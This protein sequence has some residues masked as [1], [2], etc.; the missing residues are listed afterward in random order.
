MN[1]SIE[2]RSKIVI[3]FA[4]DSG[5]GMQLTGNQFTNNSALAGNDI[6]TFPDYPAEI[7]APLGTVAGVSGFQIQ[8]SSLDIFTP[9]DE[10]DVLVAMNAAALKTNIKHIKRGGSI[11]VN[12][13]GFDKK[14]LRLA[15]YESNPLEDDSLQGFKVVEMDITQRTRDALAESKL[16]PKE[17]DRS[18]NMFVLGFLYW[19]YDRDMKSTLDFLNAKF[20][21]KPDILDANTRVLKAGYHYGEI[22]DTFSTRFKVEAAELPKGTY[23]GIMGNIAA[24]YGL[25]AASVKSGL[26]LYLG[27]YPITPA[28]DILHELSKQK[29]FGVKTFQAEDEIAAVSS[30]I[31]A[32]FAGNLAVTSTSGPGLALKGEAIG[33]A[34]MLELPLVVCNIMRA[35]PST[36]MPTKTEQSDLLQAMYGRNGESPLVVIAAESPSDCFMTAFEAARIAIEH[37]TPVIFLSDG[38]LGNGAEPWKFPKE[39]DLPNIKVKFATARN[40]EDDPPFYPYQRD[41]NLVRPWAIPGTK[42]LEHRVGGLAKED[43]TGD[44][45]Y[46]ADNHQKMTDLRQA[47]IDRI[48]FDIPE[49]AIEEGKEKGKLLVIA[50]GS[51][52]GA[53]KSVVRD[54]NHEGID[55]ISHVHLKYINPFPRNLGDII[56]RFDKVIVPEMNNGQLIKLLRDKYLVDAIPFNKVKGVPFM[57]RELRDKFQELL[58]N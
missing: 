28:S 10:F 48:A 56:K 12:T 45:S 23:R 27:S 44:V 13:S 42:G 38:Y 15:K 32:A 52:F 8:F 50:W 54:M 31:G 14:N 29:A 57:R 9:G 43:I 55:N 58:N 37:M 5:D 6:V 16:G 49:Q 20:K 11:I 30:A 46:D 22:T 26:P 19:M 36:G 41:E 33:L 51:T 35:G 53:I 24:S 39:A 21:H 18:K 2:E 34:V 3:K 47:K 17:K 7:R 4:G 1:N 25:V 40:Q